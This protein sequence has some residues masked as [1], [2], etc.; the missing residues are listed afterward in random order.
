MTQVMEEF[1]RILTDV[2]G[3]DLLLDAEI[4]ADT[5]LS[6]ELAL[7]SIEFV[8]L[9]EKLSGHYAE[10]DFPAFLAGMGLDQ[11]IDLTVGDVVSHIE[12]SPRGGARA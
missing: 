5:S 9:F 1:V 12:A 10:V 3:E 11:L 2:V 8:A 4:G 6:G 7:E